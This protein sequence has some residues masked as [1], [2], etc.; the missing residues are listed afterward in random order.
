MFCP[1]SSFVHHIGVADGIT[2]YHAFNAEENLSEAYVRDNKNGN[3]FS[4]DHL[5]Y[6][7]LTDGGRD[8]EKEM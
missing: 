4:V 3:L 6:H 1:V 7:K 2:V 8:K 5:M